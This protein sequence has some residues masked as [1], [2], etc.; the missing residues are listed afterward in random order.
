[1]TSYKHWFI[2]YILAVIICCELES[3]LWNY[4]LGNSKH[5][6]SFESVRLCLKLFTTTQVDQY[7]EATWCQNPYIWPAGSLGAFLWMRWS[8]CLIQMFPPRMCFEALQRTTHWLR[9]QGLHCGWSLSGCA[10]KPALAWHSPWAVGLLHTRTTL[11]SKT[12]PT[13]WGCS[14][15]LHLLLWTTILS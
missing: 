6:A 13:N 5:L 8:G 14:G 7:P 15:D 3:Q 11:R 4:S 12:V 1:M 10:S 2:Y 9:L